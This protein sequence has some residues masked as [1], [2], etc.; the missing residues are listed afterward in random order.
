VNRFTHRLLI[1]AICLLSAMPLHAGDISSDPASQPPVTD[2]AL[3]AQHYREVLQ[4]PEFHAP[5]EIDVNTRFKDW[6]SLWFTHLGTKLGQFQY[7][8]EM[9]SFSLLLLAVLV[10]LALA[11]LIYTIAR[12][13]RR[14]GHLEEAS[15]RGIPGQKIFHAPEFY[16]E[17]IGRAIGAGDWHAAWLVTWRQFLSRLENRNLVEADRTRTNREYLAQLRRQAL[18]SHAFALLTTMV[19]AYDRFIYGLQPIGESDW[20]LF[21]RQVDETVLLL[22]LNEKNSRLDGKQGAA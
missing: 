11:G 7:A 5:E 2:P 10:I 18:P 9:H 21:H 3:V 16:E 4:R 13:S 14:R 17:E 19:D 1:P 6:L 22:H 15:P 8:Q 12:L 20:N